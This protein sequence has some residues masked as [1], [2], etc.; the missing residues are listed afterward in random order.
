[1][2]ERGCGTGDPWLGSVG[3]SCVKRVLRGVPDLGGVFERGRCGVPPTGAVKSEGSAGAGG[4]STVGVGIR[5][6]CSQW[7]VERSGLGCLLSAD[8]TFVVERGV[9]GKLDAVVG[10]EMGMEAALGVAKAG[11]RTMA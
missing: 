3:R 2:V 9:V 8:V 11:Y 4:L 7:S 10:K 5:S 1:M 6:A